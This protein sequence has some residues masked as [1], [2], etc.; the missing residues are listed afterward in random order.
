M[1]SGLSVIG[2]QGIWKCMTWTTRKW[3]ARLMRLFELDMRSLSLPIR[4]YRRIGK[5]TTI[6]RIVSAVRS[7]RSFGPIK[8]RW[9]GIDIS[10]IWRFKLWENESNLYSNLGSLLLSQDSMKSSGHEAEGRASS[11][12]SLR[13]NLSRHRFSA[14][15]VTSLWI[16]PKPRANDGRGRK[17]VY[18]SW[19]G[20][21][22]C[23]RLASPS[24]QRPCRSVLK[25]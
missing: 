20:Y 25:H 23:P 21:S 15:N 18:R 4:L 14:V 17:G 24:A 1:A 19:L 9:P 3:G 22:L 7:T 5:G 2:T 10:N 11:V 12:L 6:A 13:E 16:R 8:V